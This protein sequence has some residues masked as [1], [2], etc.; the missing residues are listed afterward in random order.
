MNKS[1]SGL[2]KFISLGIIAWVFCFYSF[3]QYQSDTT[4]WAKLISIEKDT[5]LSNK[6][7][8]NK[9][10]ILKKEFED[11]KLVKDSVYARILHKAGLYEYFSNGEVAT[12]DAIIFTLAAI[13]INSAGGKNN[14]PAYCVNSYNNLAVYYKSLRIYNIASQYYDSAL[15]WRDQF[16]VP[17]Y[18]KSLLILS[19]AQMLYKIGDYQ[20]AIEELTIG[21][22]LA[23]KDRDSALLPALFDQRAQSYIMQGYLQ[24]A[25]LEVKSA[26]NFLQLFNNSN[27]MIN[28]ILL[29]ADIFAKQHDFT[30]ALL[31]YKRGIKQRLQTSD[32]NRISDDYTDLGNIYL[33]D[34][35]NYAKAKECYLNTIKY[36][37]KAEDVEKLS[38][39][40]LNLE[41]CNFRQRN[42]KAAEQFC[43]EALKDLKVTVSSNTLTNPTALQLRFVG[44][45]ELILFIL[46]NKTELLLTQFIETNDK[47]YLS[48]CLQTAMLT[49]TLITFMRHEQLGEQSKLYWRTRTREFFTHA[50]EA[51]YL[52]HNPKLSFSLY[53]KKSG[54][55]IK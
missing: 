6:K 19:K 45:K 27:E 13:R 4:I 14:S 2:S 7:K 33:N 11:R 47:K 1:I 50:M 54:S 36:A 35:K 25:L 21:V 22:Q 41:Q 26:S 5:S 48:A 17:E 23:N 18:T 15:L 20:K 38:K 40:H 16:Y 34:L 44:N 42:Y 8:V 28:N 24:E 46:G 53:G 29:K 52:A 43:I 39:G 55:I 10:F 9:I 51:C 32:Y 37:L 12:N 49:D 30:N 3:S 31:L